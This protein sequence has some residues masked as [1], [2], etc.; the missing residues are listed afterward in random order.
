MFQFKTIFLPLIVALVALTSLSFADDWHVYESESGLFTLRIPMGVEENISTFRIAPNVV[1]QIGKAFKSVDN[2][3]YRDTKRHYIIRYEQGLG[4]KLGDDHIGE[5]IIKALDDFAAHYSKMNGKVRK[6]KDLIYQY[7]DPGGE[8]TI[9]YQDPNLGEQFVRAR[10]FFTDH[11]KIEQILIGEH[12]TMDSFTTRQFVDSMQIK[13]GYRAISGDI[14]EEWTQHDSP[15]GIFTAYLPD[16]QAPYVPGDVK[17]SQSG[18]GERISIRFYDPLWKE[19][20]FY[21]IYGYQFN[22]NLNYLRVENILK[23]QHVLRHRFKYGDIEMKRLVGE[24]GIP[25]V[26][27]DYPINPPEGFPHVD[28][29]KLHAMFS[30]NKILV[31]EIMGSYPFVNSEFMGFVSSNVEFHASAPAKVE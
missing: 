19:M 29:V 8:I 12:G 18:S 4:R 25:I 20:I 24:N 2:K 30:G 14:R 6:R 21:N 15:L 17:I 26:T 5:M 3:P 28:Q 11:G 7:S 31:H 27:S 16:K 9:S 1:T 22:Q 13:D 23:N 10:I